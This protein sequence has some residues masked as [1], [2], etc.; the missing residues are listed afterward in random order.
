MLL[1]LFTGDLIHAKTALSLGLVNR[2][3][4]ADD[5]ERSVGSLAERIAIAPLSVLRLTKLA[6]NRAYEAMGLRQAVN[7]NLDVSA[8]LNAGDS[9]EQRAFDEIVRSEGL[10]A[11]L[12]W[13]DERYGGRLGSGQLA[14]G[15]NVRSAHGETG[16]T[17]GPGGPVGPGRGR[18][19]S[20]RRRRSSRRVVFSVGEVGRWSTNSSRRGTA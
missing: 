19:G 15:R 1:L 4:P 14:E 2:V 12:A 6:L 20:P 10:K 18:G 5:L 13:R 16:E 8:I 9:P 7:A 17:T 3:V 11:A